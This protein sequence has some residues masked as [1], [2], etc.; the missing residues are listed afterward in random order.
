LLASGL[1]IA[2]I[3]ATIRLAKKN[4]LACLLTLRH[5]SQ[6]GQ[7]EGS[8]GE[9]ADINRQALAAGADIIDLEWNSE[10]SRQLLAEQAPLILSYHNFAHMPDAA[11]L[12]QIT[13]NMLSAHP[14]AI[15]IV[16]AAATLGDAVRMLDW[17]RAGES[18]TIR[19]IGFAMGR[20]GECS[21]ILTTA[22]GAPVTYATFGKPVA[23]GQIALDVLLN[24]YRIKDLDQQTTLIA[25]TGDAAFCAQAVAELNQALHKKNAAQV[26]VAFANLRPDELEKYRTSLRIAAIHAQ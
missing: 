7:F 8:E 11:E 12:T 18:A 3:M 17:V 5:P 20:A 14:L 22:F 26:A 10:A 9:R 23:P 4:A 2:D 25:V 13:R 21:R 15:K 1:S 19:R 16:P 24:T 6:G